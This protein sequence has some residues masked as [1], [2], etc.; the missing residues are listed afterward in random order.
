MP[1]PA[2]APAHVRELATALSQPKA[3]RRGSVS[4]RTIKCSKPS[5]AC[6]ADPKARHGPYF[7]LTRSVQGKTQSRFLTPQQAQIARQQIA[8]GHRF[9]DQLDD[10]WEACEGWADTQLEGPEAA[11][12]EAAKK[13]GLQP[14][15]K[16]RWRK[17]SK[18]S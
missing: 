5:C 4:E 17:K 14:S 8:E 1:K 15:S 6:A 10:Y 18:P 16:S 9:R 2:D 12:E 7:S 11:A 13:G 3:M